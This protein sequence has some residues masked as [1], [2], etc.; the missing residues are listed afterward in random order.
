RAGLVHISDSVGDLVL[1][2]IHATDLIADSQGAILQ[3]AAG[4]DV[5]QTTALVAGDGSKIT[6]DSSNNVLDGS[7]S[8]KGQ[9]GAAGAVTIHSAMATALASV[10]GATLAVPSAG[11]IQQQ[12]GISQA[13]TANFQAATGAA[14]TLDKLNQ[15]GKILAEGAAGSAAGD[16]VITNNGSLSLD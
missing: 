7:I 9:T 15:I 3:D 11:T 2:D 4:L 12:S 13:G 14:I 10:H 1:G 8:A 16:V 6:L 5:L